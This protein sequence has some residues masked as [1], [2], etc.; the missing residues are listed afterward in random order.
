MPK[1]DDWL[2]YLLVEW[3][4]WYDKAVFGLGFAGATIEARCMEY[5]TD[6]VSDSGQKV[7]MVPYYWP[8]H[9]V[10]RVHG[11]ILSMSDVDRGA[12]TLYYATNL[13][14]RTVSEYLEVT[15]RTFRYRVE[16]ARKRLR[17][18]MCKKPE[19]ETAEN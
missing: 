16:A 7:P 19:L 12:L 18:A 15:D 11:Y 17:K 6:G 3:G 14:Q 13:D 4:E 8:N 2:H 5:G 9:R 1:R 10:S